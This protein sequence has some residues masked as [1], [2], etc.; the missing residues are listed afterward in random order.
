MY[1]SLKLKIKLTIDLVKT[2]KILKGFYK[3]CVIDTTLSI[4][5]QHYLAMVCAQQNDKI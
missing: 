5:A 2:L 1:V 3:L 4:T